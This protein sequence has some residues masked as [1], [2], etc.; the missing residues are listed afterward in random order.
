M[1]L[2]GPAELLF[3]ASEVSYE[4]LALAFTA[5]SDEPMDDVF[6]LFDE[7]CRK[8]N[9]H[10]S[11]RSTRLQQKLTF[12]EFIVNTSD[13]A[14]HETVLFLLTKVDRWDVSKAV[15]NELGHVPQVVLDKFRQL[16]AFLVL[17]ECLAS[18]YTAKELCHML[19]SLGDHTTYSCDTMDKA[20]ACQHIVNLLRLRV[21][22]QGRVETTK[23]TPAEAVLMLRDIF[24][25]GSLGLVE[26]VHAQAP[27][28]VTDVLQMSFAK[29]NMVVHAVGEWLR[30]VMRLPADQADKLTRELQSRAA[31]YGAVLTAFMYYP[32]E[33]GPR[34]Q[35]LVDMNQVRHW[36]AQLDR[37]RHTRNFG[38]PQQY[39][40]IPLPSLQQL[41][42]NL[43]EKTQPLFFDVATQLA[44]KNATDRL[45]TRRYFQQRSALATVSQLPLEELRETFGQ[46]V[47]RN[48][49]K[50]MQHVTQTN[51]ILSALRDQPWFHER[52]KED[53]TKLKNLVDRVAA[54]KHALNQTVARF[55]SQPEQ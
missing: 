24:N 23:D 32:S 27:Q 48:T 37:D 47:R 26:N 19:D 31:D 43:T 42:K 35:Y 30:D 5:V 1:K 46:R 53:A 51:H 6:V 28:Q 29:L 41:E 55:A 39:M 15:L 54:R 4:Q 8:N 50:T 21:T 20:E 22:P 49:Q 34:L 52:N 40:G 2:L 3:V 16:P 45:R 13:A 7:W 10:I 17:P 12:A 38:A 11:R 25:L 36:A 33:A 9:L 18:R 14:F 44:I